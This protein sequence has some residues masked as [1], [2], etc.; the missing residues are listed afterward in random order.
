MQSEPDAADRAQS[1]G[2]SRS[3]PG[4]CRRSRRPDSLNTH[5]IDTW[6]ARCARTGTTRYKLLL[7]RS[8]RTRRQVYVRDRRTRD[9]LLKHRLTN[10]C[11][12]PV[13]LC[14]VCAAYQRGA[15]AT[16][17]V[18]RI[19]TTLCKRLAGAS[20]RR[21][22]PA[23][24]TP[25]WTSS[26]NLKPRQHCLCGVANSTCGPKADASGRTN[27]ELPHI[28]G[29]EDIGEELCVHRRLARQSLYA[30]HLPKTTNRWHRDGW[31]GGLGHF[32]TH[33]DRWTL[34]QLIAR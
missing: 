3:R 8:P 18:D 24:P 30:D 27:C 10:N 9:T 16:K 12:Q 20:R 22:L 17:P 13:S 23:S 29:P 1:P 14:R 28:G 19:Q 32:G 33:V 11:A 26:A 31:G 6:Q 34:Q 4:P 25:L 21:H 5:C 7:A 15:F 2:P